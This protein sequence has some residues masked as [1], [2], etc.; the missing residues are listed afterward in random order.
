M[1]TQRTLK[2]STP[3][4]EFR[5]QNNCFVLLLFVFHS[6]NLTGTQGSEQKVTVF[7]GDVGNREGSYTNS[8]EPCQDYFKLFT[9][10]SPL[11]VKESIFSSQEFVDLES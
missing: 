5:H 11:T 8:C 1:Y 3:A 6:E 10:S 4:E 9:S 7:P 2:P